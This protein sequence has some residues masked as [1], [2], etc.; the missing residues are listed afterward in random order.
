MKFKKGDKVIGTIEWSDSYNRTGIVIG[1]INNFL[2]KIKFDDT[3]KIARYSEYKFGN[4]NSI[5]Q[6]FIKL[7]E[8]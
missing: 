8:N 4:Y 6:T 7:L 5:I 3:N 2:V 1:Y